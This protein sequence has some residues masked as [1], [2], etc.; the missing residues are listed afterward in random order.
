MVSLK[1]DRSGLPLSGYWSIMLQCNMLR[2]RQLAVKEQFILHRTITQQAYSAR[3]DALSEP[4]EGGPQRRPEPGQTASLRRLLT[5]AAQ[6]TCD[7]VRAWSVDRHGRSLLD[8]IG[9]LYELSALWTGIL[10]Q[11]GAALLTP[12]TDSEACILSHLQYVVSR[13]RVKNGL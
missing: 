9:F 5:N 7:V 4:Q 1:N 6:R 12:Y 2:S 3:S 13:R 8:L 10:R 11:N